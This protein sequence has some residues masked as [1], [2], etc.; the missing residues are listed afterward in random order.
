MTTS[1]LSKDRQKTQDHQKNIHGPNKQL[2]KQ[3]AKFMDVPTS[4][5]NETAFLY[6]YWGSHVCSRIPDGKRV[7]LAG[8]FEDG[9][10]IKCITTKGVVNNQNVHTS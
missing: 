1:C 3:W 10:V 6:T 2:L 9:R 4:K 7:Y 5:A 8:S